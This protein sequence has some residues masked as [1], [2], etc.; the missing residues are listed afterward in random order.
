MRK[1][2]ASFALLV[3]GQLSTHCRPQETP[4]DRH[5]E[6]FVQGQSREGRQYDN[7]ASSCCSA[8]LD[9]AHRYLLDRGLT[10][11]LIEVFGLGFCS[12]GRLRDRVCIPIHSP[13]GAKFLAYSGRWA[14]DDVPDGIPR[15]LMPRGFKK[16]EVLFNYHRVVGAQH[17]VIV[18]GY[19]SVFRLHALVVVCN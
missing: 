7:N 14:S 16:S 8:T 10:P 12:H 18:E 3:D 2:F 17:L 6:S 4:E 11:E 13:D 1:V 15:Y 9:P 5:N 19:W